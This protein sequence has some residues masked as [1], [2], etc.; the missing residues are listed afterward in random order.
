M[1]AYVIYNR[2]ESKRNCWFINELIKEF[3]TLG[4]KLK[5]LIE[6]DLQLTINNKPTILY[7]SKQIDIPNFVINRTNNYIVATQFESMGIKVFNNSNVSHFT[8]NKYL[9]Y[10]KL[11]SYGIPVLNTKLVIKN[12]NID[13]DNFPVVIKPL[14]GKGG[15]DVYLCKN[16]Y[17]LKENSNKISDDNFIVQQVASDI[18]KDLRVYILGN[19]IYKAILRVSKNGFKSNYC[20]GNDAIVYEL[21]TDE[22]KLINRILEFENFDYVGID[23]LFHNNKIIF[24]EIE[25]SVGAR[26]LY[27]K[28]DLNVARDLARYIETIL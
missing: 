5:L 11:S 26:M 18:G 23:F 10:L 6:E 3:E 12:I 15:A 27:D 17:E 25:D 4:I 7:E 28:T 9:T 20:L 1:I 24:N 2:Y 22:L 21:N 14:S 8:N 16:K 13:V 19:K